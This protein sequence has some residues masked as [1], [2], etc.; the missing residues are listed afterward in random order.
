[1]ILEYFDMPVMNFLAGFIGKSDLFDRFVFALARYDLFKGVPMVSLFWLVWFLRPQGETSGQQDARQSRLLIVLAGSVA[2]AILSRILQV[3]LHV[4]QRPIH[5]GLG[6]NYPSFVDPA[7]LNAWNAFPSDHSMLFIALATGLW[8]VNRRIGIFAFLWTIIVIDLPRIYLGIHYP[9][10]VIAG[11]VFGLLF[12]LGFE[13]LP[14][15]RKETDRLLAWSKRHQ[16]IFYWGVFILTDQ[17]AH[18]F[19]DVRDF[20]SALFKTIHR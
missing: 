11:A 14:P 13:R 7:T 10:D 1:M 18:L 12:M 17:T 16:A 15:V 19:D 20:C 4:H 5:A 8:L 3:A 6:I 9:S 2:A